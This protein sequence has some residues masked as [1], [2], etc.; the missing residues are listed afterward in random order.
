[1]PVQA[2]ARAR[3]PDGTCLFVEKM[4]SAWNPESEPGIPRVIAFRLFGALCPLNIA[5]LGAAV[6]FRFVALERQ[7]ESNQVHM[8]GQRD[9]S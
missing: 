8:W 1:M 9:V 5:G 6:F 3:A 2:A 7:A 4:V